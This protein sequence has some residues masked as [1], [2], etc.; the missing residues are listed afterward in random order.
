M[1]RGAMGLV[2][3]M[4]TSRDTAIAL[5]HELNRQQ[6]MAGDDDAGHHFAKVYQQAAATTLDQLGFSAYVLGATGRGLLRNA[7]EFMATDHAVAELLGA[8]A[9][10]TEGFGDPGAECSENFLG[11]GQHLPGTVGSTAWYDQY[12]PGGRSDRFRGSPEKLRDVATS[13]RHAGQLVLRLLED[14]QAYASTAGKAHSGLAAE[15]FQTYFKNSV[16]TGCPPALA[17]ED[18]PLV[19]NLVAACNQLAKACD[20]YADHVQDAKLKIQQHHADPFTFDMPWNQPMFG[21][22]GYDGG[23]KDA[24]LDDPYIHQLGDVAHA[25]DSSKARIRLPQGS[26]GPSLPWW[27]PF[28]PL[29]PG[30]VPAPFALASYSGQLPGVLPMGNHVDPAVPWADPIPP[31]PGTTRLLSPAEQQRFRTWMNSLSPGGFAGGGGPRNPDNAYQ[32]RVAGYPERE[33]PL[34]GRKTGL[35]VDG[36]RPADGYLVE[37]KHVRDPDCRKKSFRSLD[38]VEETLANPVK[39]KMVNGEAKI[40]W[41]PVVDSMYA[42]DEAELTRYKKAMANPANS[43]IRGLEVVTNGKDNAAYWQ[44]MMAMTGTPGS[45]RYVP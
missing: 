21:G 13:W 16:G 2:D 28:P 5:R 17:R 11:L 26:G 22:N 40:Q 18:E 35:M 10:L 39:V 45:T 33:V 24:V 34:E 30:P 23:L 37:A 14:A 19:T 15:S 29:I 1:I 32:L 44:S 3:A 7:R 25:L 12:A 36:I 27:R 43:E 6:G 8:Q 4:T 31:V 20:R 42:G 38:R 41:D 9:D